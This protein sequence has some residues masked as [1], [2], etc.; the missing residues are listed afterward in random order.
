MKGGV[1]NSVYLINCIELR[2]NY[3][4]GCL[5]SQQGKRGQVTTEP[6]RIHTVSG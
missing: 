1:T 5:Y 4:S 6:V 3:A 2:E